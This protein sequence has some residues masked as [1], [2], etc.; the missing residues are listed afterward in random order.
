MDIDPT[1]SSK[2]SINELIYDSTKPIQQ[3][4]QD[5]VFEK[6]KHAVESDNYIKDE[7]TPTGKNAIMLACMMRMEKLAL[8]LIEN[9]IGDFNAIS[10][11]GLTPLLFAMNYKLYSVAEELVNHGVDLKQ[12]EYKNKMNAFALACAGKNQELALIIFEKMKND[13]NTLRDVLYSPMASDTTTVFIIACKARLFQIVK[14]L[15]ELQYTDSEGTDYLHI[16]FVD[17]DNY[18]CRHYLLVEMHEVLGAK[19]RLELKP[20]QAES[21]QNTVQIFDSLLLHLLKLYKNKPNITYTNQL[22]DGSKFK[23]TIITLCVINGFVHS[24]DYATKYA[25]KADLNQPTFYSKTPFM[26]LSEKFYKDWRNRDIIMAMF[27]MFGP[28]MRSIN[29]R[30]RDEEGATAITGFFY[31]GYYEI[32][33]FLLEKKFI[34][35]KF[36]RNEQFL[37]K[38]ILMVGCDKMVMNYYIHKYELQQE[39]V[40]HGFQSLIR[41]CKIVVEEDPS[42]LH[43]K[44]GDGVP[45]LH[46]Y[47]GI[48]GS[49][50]IIQKILETS[51]ST[52]VNI[53][54]PTHQTALTMACY[55]NNVPVAKYLLRLPNIK[56][57][58]GDA[59][60]NP[61]LLACEC[62]TEDIALELLKRED[63]Q[64]N[65]KNTNNMTPFLLACSHGMTN[66]VLKLLDYP[67][68]DVLHRNFFS[69]TP[70]QM[71]SICNLGRPVKEKMEAM[72]LPTEMV[73]NYYK[74]DID[75]TIYDVYALE[76]KTIQ[77]YLDEDPENFCFILENEGN[78]LYGLTKIDKIKSAVD[79]NNIHNNNLFYGC[80]DV[81][82]TY[83]TGYLWSGDPDRQQIAI[84]NVDQTF[85][86]AYLQEFA[87]LN[88]FVY[89]PA[90]EALVS[91]PSIT[92]RCY[93]LDP[94]SHFQY[95][96]VINSHLIDSTSTDST[97]TT[98]C[99]TIP[100]PIMYNIIPCFLSKDKP[101][102]KKRARSPEKSPEVVVKKPHLELSELGQ[103]ISINYR[104]S[105][106]HIP[107]TDTTTLKELKTMF[108]EKLVEKEIIKEIPESTNVMFVFLGKLYRTRG[109]DG[110]TKLVKRDIVDKHPEYD[111]IVLV[112]NVSFPAKKGGRQTRKGSSSQSKR[113]T[114]RCN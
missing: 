74:Y 43:E 105:L 11:E 37:N 8:Y 63:I 4:N 89:H 44:D 99:G 80:R 58:V 64:V 109:E 16:R 56:Y 111:K 75:E 7:Y 92:H 20:S 102:T 107:Y 76:N 79:A 72:V 9:K 45:L 14:L 50:P 48:H 84:D 46:Y 110:D 61:L 55:T 68:D 41:I 108:L 62:A 82:E 3:I 39:L 77:Q 31:Y 112:S 91:Y 49:L 66:V 18:D 30:E 38:N 25:T 114:R 95:K 98:H 86:F 53:E 35:A 22:P 73:G 36:L 28:K 10:N 42:F 47:A 12:R 40:D 65:M 1:T 51:H 97:G 100:K 32:V 83:L 57:N 21:I 59:E 103:Y 71:V 34:T 60:T 13:K 113:K 33:L 69:I 19:A 78:R 81:M 70:Y 106:Y 88:A 27:R 15:I 2:I 5:D 54:T 104:D 52:D 101:A 85:L 29:V 23:S 67:I 24:L 87:I 94:N 26:L 90:L 17:P 6:V 93:F 96:S